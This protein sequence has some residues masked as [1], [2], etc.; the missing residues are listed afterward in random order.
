MA[1]LEAVSAR[2]AEQKFS[3]TARELRLSSLGALDKLNRL[4]ALVNLFEREQPSSSPW[5]STSA[6][7][8]AT[9]RFC[10]PFAR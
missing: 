1:V 8:A 5:C 10:A 2:R 3:Q 9:R 7:V 4:F 6:S